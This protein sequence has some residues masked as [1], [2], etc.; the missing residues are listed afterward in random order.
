[1]RERQ[2]ADGYK[3]LVQS[4]RAFMSNFWANLWLGS[5]M[6]LP[7]TLMSWLY[8]Q[9]YFPNVVV[10][11]ITGT[12]A[13]FLIFSVSSIALILHT[14]KVASG[15][16]EGVL[17][18]FF[19]SFDKLLA[20]W[21]LGFLTLLLVIGGFLFFIISGVIIAIRL[22]LGWYVLIAENKRGLDAIVRSGNLVRRHTFAVLIRWII[23]YLP[24]VALSLAGYFLKPLAP[25]MYE[26][27]YTALNV[28]T[29]PFVTIYGY[30]LY[31]ELAFNSSL[32]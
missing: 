26:V 7:F 11:L 2:I 29:L 5:L 24:L 28:F 19:D 15:Y 31:K 22:S 21:W 25:T 1:M 13:A 8:Y 3:L 6:V 18:T 32:I 9:T 30:F 4:Y 27:V 23:P 12:I 17:V 16:M 10:G 20:Y 14:H